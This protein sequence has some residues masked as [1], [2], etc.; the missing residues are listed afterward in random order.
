M[1]L[2]LRALALTAILGAAGLSPSN[3][4]FGTCRY[5]CGSTVH[6]TT[7]SSMSSC[8]GQPFTCPNG[9]TGYGFAYR[10]RFWQ[11]CGPISS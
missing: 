11:F 7:V 3:A 5:L 6:E 4:A 1:K 8:C 9:Q 10:E 2:L